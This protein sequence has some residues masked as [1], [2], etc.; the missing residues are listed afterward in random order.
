MRG[1]GYCWVVGDIDDM[2]LSYNVLTAGRGFNLWTWW[3]TRNI[4]WDVRRIR[5]LRMKSE[6]DGEVF[7]EDDVQVFDERNFYSGLQKK[8]DTE[9]KV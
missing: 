2:R 5:R 7:G 8:T 4:E 9:G 6:K 3:L 1:C